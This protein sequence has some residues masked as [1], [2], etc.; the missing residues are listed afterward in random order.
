MGAPNC[1]LPQL[2]LRFVKD[3]QDPKDILIF[4]RH[5]ATGEFHQ[6]VI[7]DFRFR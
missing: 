6:P 3:A 1:V 2:I 5:L 4:L 7:G